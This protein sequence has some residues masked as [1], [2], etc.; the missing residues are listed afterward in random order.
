MALEHRAA[1][2]L[3]RGDLVRPGAD[4]LGDD[5]GAALLDRFLRHDAAGDVADRDVEQVRARL[6]EDDAAGVRAGDLDALEIDPVA[7]V[8]GVLR[9]RRGKPD[10]LEGELHVLGRHLAEAVGEHLARLEPELDQRGRGLLHLG[11]SVELEL[12]RVRLLLH[13][14]LVDAPDDVPVRGPNALGGVEVGDVAVNAHRDAAART[15]GLRL[16]SLRRGDAA[17]E[18]RGGGSGKDL[19]AIEFDGHLS[20]PNRMP[21]AVIMAVRL[22]VSVTNAVDFASR[23]SD[24]RHS[25]ANPGR[26]PALAARMES[27]VDRAGRNAR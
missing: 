3:D 12:G 8:G 20:L 26:E 5:L 27:S 14:T 24:L 19:T 18:A 13:Q 7:L 15:R 17:H 21:H 4:R 11:G 16:G 1:L 25:K 2:A 10:A 23:I 6:R 22:S 9:A